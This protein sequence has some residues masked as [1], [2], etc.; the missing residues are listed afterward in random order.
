MVESAPMSSHRFSR[1]DLKHDEF[2]TTTSQIGRWLMERR[3]RIGWGLIAVVVLISIVA[4]VQVYQQRQESSASALLAVAMEVYRTPLTEEPAPPAV[5]EPAATDDAGEV[6]VEEPAG[7][8]TVAAEEDSG[9]GSDPADAASPEQPATDPG[10]STSA[11]AADEHS[12][13]GQRHFTTE[14]A[15]CEAAR[16]EFAPIVQRY[17]R[18]P[19][20]RVASFY[21]GLCEISLGNGEAATEALQQAAGASQEIIATVS[22]YRLGQLQLAEGKLDEAIAS[23]DL[24]LARNSDAFPADEALMSKA[25]AQEAAGDQRG[26]MIS[27]QRVVDEHPDS[28]SATDARGRVEELAAELGLDPNIE[29]S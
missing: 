15:R 25:R 1:K 14:I 9:E 18:T 11:A 8:T 5:T 28:F 24:L 12:A 26:A 17:G 21:L 27:Y 23:F 13:V 22:L 6:A 4:M 16:E 3:R 10:T 7:E 29:R 20:G 19:S 2:V